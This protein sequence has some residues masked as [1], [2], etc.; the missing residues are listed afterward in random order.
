V[1]GDRKLQ[2][3]D[4]VGAIETFSEGIRD[5]PDDIQNYYGRAKAYCLIG[6]L[7][8]AI[9]D[10]TQ[11]IRIQPDNNVAYYRRAQIYC[12][13][14]G[15]YNTGKAI[16][17][18]TRAID[19]YPYYHLSY[20]HRTMAYAYSAQ[21]DK[22]ISDIQKYLKVAEK[23]HPILTTAVPMFITALQKRQIQ[24]WYRIWEQ[25]KHEAGPID[26]L[27]MELWDE[28]DRKREQAIEALAQIGEPALSTLLVALEKDDRNSEMI[29]YEN[30]WLRDAIVALGKPAILALSNGLYLK[31]RL[32]RAS[33]KTLWKFHDPLAKECL[34]A[35][36][37]SKDVMDHVKY[38]VKE[39]LHMMKITKNSH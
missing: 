19:L 21:F 32:A 5:E 12:G 20:L 13:A 24:D 8:A 10:L 22:A 14:S 9:E 25:T 29:E 18:Y 27:V 6:N 17:D 16:A 26:A 34:Q 11:V 37:V 38:Y 33:A 7:N 36:L 35:A 3:N 23:W 4:I 30:L 31:T 15:Q 2:N 28:D 1:E 39:P